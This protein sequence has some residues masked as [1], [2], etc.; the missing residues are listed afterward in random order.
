MHLYNNNIIIHSMCIYDQINLIGGIRV[1][2]CTFGYILNNN[3]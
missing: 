3:Q 2:I 1:N